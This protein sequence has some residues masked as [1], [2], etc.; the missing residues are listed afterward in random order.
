MK[1]NFFMGPLKKGLIKAAEESEF[2]FDYPFLICY[3]NRNETM[4]V[5]IQKKKIVLDSKVLKHPSRLISGLSLCSSVLIP[6]YTRRQCIKTQLFQ[7]LLCFPACLWAV[8]NQK[9]RSY[10]Q[11]WPQYTKICKYS[12]FFWF[13]VSEPE[14]EI[15][16]Q[17]IP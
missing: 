14:T 3:N 17:A 4:S 1:E 10:L 6:G 15:F 13:A 8:C 9:W 16:A 7:T 11:T 12:H 5:L 2:Y